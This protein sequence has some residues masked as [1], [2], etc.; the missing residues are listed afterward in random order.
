MATSS[1]QK[2]ATVVGVPMPLATI[3]EHTADGQSTDQT[4]AIMS[5]SHEQKYL[6]AMATIATLLDKVGNL[7]E[8]TEGTSSTSTAVKDFEVPEDWS[9]NY[10]TMKIDTKE[11]DFIVCT[12]RNDVEMHKNV[13]MHS[14][15]WNK[16]WTGSNKHQTEGAKGYQMYWQHTK[17]D[18]KV[19]EKVD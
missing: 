10:T 18:K 17:Y 19:W 8:K 12:Y 2:L 4:S 9:T 15:M 13:I 14:S 5:T 11:I 1:D 3:A 7:V 6:H 16:F